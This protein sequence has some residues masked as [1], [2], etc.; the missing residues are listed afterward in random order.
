MD[1]LKT[2]K[3]LGAIA[4]QF[5]DERG[6]AEY[7][8]PKNLAMSVVIETA[9]LLEIFQ[10]TTPEDSYRLKD[11][12]KIKEHLGEEMADVLAYLLNLSECLEIDLSEA[13]VD[14]MKKN[15]VKYPKEEQHKF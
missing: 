9:E 1:K 15:A 13:F 10:W 12:P 11:D 6:W 14:K 8:T 4:S 7:H 2:L 3:D 5:V